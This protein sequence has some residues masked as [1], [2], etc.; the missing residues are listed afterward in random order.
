MTYEYALDKPRKG[1]LSVTGG[2][3]P[4]PIALR[5]ARDV[6]HRPV[7][8]SLLVD[9]P[10]DEIT[11]TAVR[12]LPI[13]DILRDIQHRLGTGDPIEA[14]IT[15]PITIYRA[16]SA[17]RGL[18]SALGREHFEA[19]ARQV[20]ERPDLTPLNALRQR[21]PDVGYHTHRRWLQRAGDMGL[22][23]QEGGSR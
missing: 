16:G 9:P 4:W 22:L 12:E 11:P 5:V 20:Q 14:V 1:W 10:E 17:P 8:L 23:G 18:R 2:N 6:F 13:G 21:W 15:Q 3:L 19:V 7:I